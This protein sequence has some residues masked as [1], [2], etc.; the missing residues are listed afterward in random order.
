MEGLQS[1]LGDSRLNWGST[2]A[3]HR[4][5]V[6]RL[7]W[8]RR[9]TLLAS[10]S[11]DTQVLIWSVQNINGGHGNLPLKLKCSIDTAHS[12]NI[13]AV[14]FVD[15]D[16]CVVSAGMDTLVVVNDIETNL[17][18]H[19]Y[20]CHNAR[21]KDL[22]VDIETDAIFWTA[23]E[24]GVVNQFDVRMPGDVCHR[25]GS[26]ADCSCKHCYI[27]APWAFKSITQ[28]PT[29]PW[30]LA[31]GTDN[32]YV[33]L[34]D[35]RMLQT[36]TVTRDCMSEN[37]QINPHTRPGGSHTDPFALLSYPVLEARHDVH[38]TYAA[39]SD[40]GAQLAATYNNENAYIF[41]INEFLGRRKQ[42]DDA[43]ADDKQQQPLT[44]PPLSS[45]SS[46]VWTEAR[47][48]AL[49]E[50]GN[51]LLRM[52][53]FRD[54]VVKY[55][56]AIRAKNRVPN[57]PDAKSS[58]L[59]S[60][61]AVALMLAAEGDGESCV[62]L[63]VVD[64][65]V[66]LRFDYTVKAAYCKIQCLKRMDLLEEAVRA[67]EDA[68]TRFTDD[69]DA[70]TR[71]DKELA[72]VT[73]SLE[74]EDVSHRVTLSFPPTPVNFDRRVKMAVISSFVAYS[75]MMSKPEAKLEDVEDYLHSSVWTGDRDDERFFK[76]PVCACDDCDQLEVRAKRRWSEVLDYDAFWEG[77]VDDALWSMGRHRLVG[78][79]NTH[80]D[81][82]ELRFWGLWLLAA[83]DEGRICIFD[84]RTGKLHHHSPKVTVAPLNSVAPHATHPFFV[85]SGIDSV[86]HVVA[87]ARPLE[88]QPTQKPFRGT[89]FSLFF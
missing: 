22:E 10:G 56:E 42:L 77:K 66:A 49:K 34:Y 58:V 89:S 54:A 6:N 46:D 87:L 55:S 19:T 70:R 1:L 9:G 82:K 78:A 37:G 48:D 84:R 47:V 88:E 44:S 17:W 13:F 2:A 73:S 62:E 67:C 53:M 23:D 64:L 31:M 45:S 5:C 41:E 20:T 35:R 32:C 16:S 28:N 7:A 51:E 33:S 68:Q 12:E 71:F 76:Y 27:T 65:D 43:S 21:V 29:R 61:R 79:V 80:T 39:F 24:H 81:I 83:D 40:D 50:L 4:G 85:S 8:N 15:R 3:E 52:E 72:L 38:C 75:D 25:D 11:D 63:A 18:V 30:M 74:Q 86:L 60:N 59:Y 57:Y 69:L 26:P 14:G 36:F